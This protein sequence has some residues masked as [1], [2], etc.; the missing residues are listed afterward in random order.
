MKPKF[1]L[2]TFRDLDGY[3][4]IKRLSGGSSIGRKTITNYEI[5]YPSNLDQQKKRMIRYRILGDGRVRKG[6]LYSPNKLHDS[7][8]GVFKDLFNAQ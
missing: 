2:L 7:L 5:L 8:R 1:I 4:V 6:T 3:Y